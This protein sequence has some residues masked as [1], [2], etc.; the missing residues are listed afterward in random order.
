MI[1]WRLFRIRSTTIALHPA[2]LIYWLY[3]ILVGHGLLMLLATASILIHEAAHAIVSAILGFPPSSLELTPLGAVMHAE[4]EGRIPPLKLL[5]ILLAGPGVT[6]LLC[7]IALQ[8]TKADILSAH[9]GSV[10]F[11]CNLSIFLINVLPVLP[12]DG[13]RIL[14]A[15]LKA[16]LPI[17]CVHRILRCIGTCI[18][19]SLICLNI[20][21]SWHSGGWNLSLAFVGCFILYGTKRY[22]TSQ[23]YAE[24]CAFLERKIRLERK[25]HLPVQAVIALGHTPIRELIRDLPPRKCAI[26]ICLEDGTHRML[27]ILTEYELIQH[28]MSTPETTLKKAACLSQNHLDSAKYDTK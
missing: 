22:T 2:T 26:Y 11:C 18:G 24:M 10:L 15:I 28:Y 9:S 12:L 8:L 3:G 7:C 25:E 14:S 4:D 13:G 6:L 1:S 20:Y 5:L 17:R 16:F 27:G 23:A 19:M 21:I